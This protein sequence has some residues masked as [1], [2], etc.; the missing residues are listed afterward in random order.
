MSDSAPRCLACKKGKSCLLQT[1]TVL[2]AEKSQYVHLLLQG[3][4]APTG[5]VVSLN[6]Y[7]NISY[8][9]VG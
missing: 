1:I 8:W 6:H 2:H 3:C 4:M 7:A 5:G 9:K